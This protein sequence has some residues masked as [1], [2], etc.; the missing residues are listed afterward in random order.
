M[1]VLVE[2]NRKRPPKSSHSCAPISFL[3]P[4]PFHRPHP[5]PRPTP[6]PIAFRRVYEY[7][8][9]ATSLTCEYGALV[10][11]GCQWQR[12]SNGVTADR[13][14]KMR[15]QTKMESRNSKKDNAEKALQ[16]RKQA[17]LFPKKKGGR[18][19]KCTTSCQSVFRF[20]IY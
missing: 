6:T 16:N 5:P 13:Q 12:S 8:L 7:E 9:P 15:R 14:T 19:K 10:R 17:I 20:L 18:Y 3:S 11:G 1:A 2:R 4:I